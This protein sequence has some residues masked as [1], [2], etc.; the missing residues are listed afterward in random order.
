[1]LNVDI[2]VSGYMYVLVYHVT[3]MYQCIKLVICINELGYIVCI[4]SP[5]VYH[6]L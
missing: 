1:M 2:S 5:N 6:E 3:C 4:M